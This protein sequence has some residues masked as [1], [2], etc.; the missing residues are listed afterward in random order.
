MFLHFGQSLFAEYLLVLPGANDMGQHD[1]AAGDSL[2]SV[3]KVSRHKTLSGTT[4]SLG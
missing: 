2:E 3:E 4:F 1:I